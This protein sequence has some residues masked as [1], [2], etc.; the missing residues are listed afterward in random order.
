M[1]LEDIVQKRI[2]ESNSLEDLSLIL[3]YLIA[4]HSVWTDGRLYSIRTLVDVVDGLKIEI[5]HNEHPPPHFHVK[6]NGIDASFSIKECQFIVGKIGSREQM[7]V[8]WWYK[9]SRLK[10]IQFWP[11]K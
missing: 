11:P 10:L 5:Y 1:N 6:A 2:N 9:K 4:Y 3:K 8:E 7:M